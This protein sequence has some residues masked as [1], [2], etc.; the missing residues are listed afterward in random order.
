MYTN[1]CTILQDKRKGRKWEGVGE[2]RK[3]GGGRVGGRGGHVLF[4][5]MS[6][7]N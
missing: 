7:K 1:Q 6:Y 3:G 4:N 5:S 2:R